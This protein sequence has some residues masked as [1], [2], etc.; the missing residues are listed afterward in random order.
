MNL[1]SILFSLPGWLTIAALVGAG[2]AP[3]S[4]VINVEVTG[5]LVLVGQKGEGE[6]GWAVTGYVHAEGRDLLLDCSSNP[7]AQRLLKA[8]FV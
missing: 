6:K 4:G 5:R 8:E 2:E 7:A 3:A 1:V